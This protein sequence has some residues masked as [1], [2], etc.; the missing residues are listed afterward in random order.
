MHTCDVQICLR[1]VLFGDL[2]VTLTLSRQLH[3]CRPR[4]LVAMRIC[5]MLV[6]FQIML[7]SECSRRSWTQCNITERLRDATLHIYLY[8]ASLRLTSERQVLRIRRIC[9][10]FRI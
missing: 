4:S 2:C 10:D 5:C 8:E 1:T 7:V 3:V 6:S 9:I